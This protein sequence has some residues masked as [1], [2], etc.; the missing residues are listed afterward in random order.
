[1]GVQGVWGGPTLGWAGHVPSLNLRGATNT[2]LSP[3]ASPSS[4]QPTDGLD[5][6]IQLGLAV[7]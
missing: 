6:S 2:L 7:A 4:C 3:G 1:M 5:S